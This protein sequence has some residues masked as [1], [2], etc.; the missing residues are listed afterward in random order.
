MKGIYI[1]FCPEEKDN[2]KKTV[3]II[4]KIYSQ[5]YLFKKVLCND[6][7]LLNLRRKEITSPFLKF[8]C[9]LFSNKVFDYSIFRQQ[10]FDY[11]YIRRVNPNCRSF[12][13]ILKLL[14]KNNPK[15]KILYEI[16][17]YPYDMEYDNIFAKIQFFIDKL[18]RKSLVK[19][20]D[21]IVTLSEDREIFGCKT[22]R[23]ANGVDVADIPITKKIMFNPKEISMIAVAQFSFWHGYERVIEGL[24][25]YY[26]NGG[27]CIVK[28]NLVGDG[29]D[30]EK[31]KTLVEKYNLSNFI[32]I[33]GALSGDKLNKIF[34]E[35]DVALCSLA[36]HK[37][38]IYL[39]SEL[40]SREYLCRG[41]P[42]ISSTKIDIIPNNFKYIFK[43]PEDNSNIDINSVIKFVQ[44]IYVND[45]IKQNSTVQLVSSEI[46]QFAEKNCS[47]EI[48]MEK[49]LD[50][51]KE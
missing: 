28:L 38:N 21:R 30:L 44:N 17:T 20:I 27:S 14:K 34:D 18:Y 3:G 32:I 29:P 13:Y 48:A 8:F 22:L 33:H 50:F 6:F 10:K 45:K 40:K 9:Y 24:Y 5:Y 23:I 49:V 11:V 7:E 19:Y 1:F 37:K 4:K 36:C 51:F 31:Y 43:V 2:S 41:L 16:P 12:I 35:S 25:N 47:M 39:S 42:I 26:M 46:R 15:C